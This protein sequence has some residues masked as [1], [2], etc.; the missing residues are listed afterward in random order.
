MLSRETDRLGMNVNTF[1]I[2]NDWIIKE[3]LIPHGICQVLYIHKI[4]YPPCSVK[5]IAT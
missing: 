4:Y 2:L 3:R 5:L 1:S